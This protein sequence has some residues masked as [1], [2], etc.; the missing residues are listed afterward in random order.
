MTTENDLDD[1]DVI[2]PSTV[3]G[4]KM[5]DNLS[6][7]SIPKRKNP[8]PPLRGPSSRIAGKPPIDYRLLNDPGIAKTSINQGTNQETALLG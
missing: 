1:P 3:E 5:D 7:E 2:N 8:I 6:Q 4:E